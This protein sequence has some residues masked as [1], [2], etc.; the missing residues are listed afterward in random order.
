M[1]RISDAYED[2]DIVS[3]MIYCKNPVH[4]ETP[5]DIVIFQQTFNEA[6]IPPNVDEEREVI[7]KN[8]DRTLKSILLL[9]TIGVIIC[10][11]VYYLLLY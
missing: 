3:S 4:D 7:V 10:I 2:K 5:D 8:S 6:F 1:E 9:F 11:I